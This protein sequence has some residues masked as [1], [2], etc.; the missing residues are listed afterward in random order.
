[1]DAPVPESPSRGRPDCTDARRTDCIRARGIVEEFATLLQESDG[2]RFW[3]MPLSEI[4]SNAV[5]KTGEASPT[6]WTHLLPT[7]VLSVLELLVDYMRL[8]VVPHCHRYPFVMFFI[9]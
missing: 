1:M 9:A 5:L 8:V 3:Q 4:L 7:I 6:H 2:Q